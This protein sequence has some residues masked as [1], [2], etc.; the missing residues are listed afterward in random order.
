MAFQEIA[1]HTK[2][3]LTLVA[4]KQHDKWHK[5][6]EVTQEI[7][8]I[9]FAVSLS[10]WLHGVGE[11]WHEQQQVRTFLLGL[12]RDIRSDINQLYIAMKDNENNIAH[13]R[14]LASLQADDKIDPETFKLAYQAINAKNILNPQMSR[15][16]GF[17]SAG[18][19]TNIENIVLLERIAALYQ[20]N[21]PEVRV[22][23]AAWKYNQGKFLDFLEEELS[24]SD[25]LKRHVQVMTTSKGRRFCERMQ[26]QAQLTEK[27]RAYIDLGTL[28]IKDIDRAYPGNEKKNSPPS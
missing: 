5:L 16:E 6:R 21:L 23:E 4:D 1:D 7:L 27:Y 14:Y 3:V 18:K 28:I 11:H 19:L 13:Y 26:A 25:D 8:I 15:Y 10:I 20:S 12:K 17:K 2:N 22:S 24:D 9:V